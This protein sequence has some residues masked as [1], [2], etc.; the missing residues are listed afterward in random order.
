[1]RSEGGFTEI[2]KVVSL[3]RYADGTVEFRAGSYRETIDAANLGD[4]ETYEWIKWAAI[5]AGIS[6]TEEYL[7]E[8][9]R[10]AR[11]MGR[12]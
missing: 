6:L 4:W 1:M 10:E 12:R 5:T 8:L 7:E 9:F 11:G 2:K 3:R